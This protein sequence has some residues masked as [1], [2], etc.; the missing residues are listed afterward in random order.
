MDTMN[1]LPVLAASAIHRTYRLPR[2]GPGHRRHRDALRGVDVAVGGG[3]TLGI[4]GES[5]SGKSTLARILAGLDAPTAGTVNFAGRAV[6]AR[7]PRRLRWLRREVQMIFQDPATSLDPRMTVER[8]IGEPL[9]C[10]GIEG[11]HGGRIDE[12]LDEVELGGWAKSRLPHQLSGGQQ[13][14]VAIA[15]AIAAGPSVLIGDEPVSA[16]DVGVRLQ[17][18][19][20]LRR[21]VEERR[22]ALVLISH[23]LGVVRYLCRDVSVL[24]EGVVV[25]HGPT[26]RVFSAPS[27]VYTRRLVAAVPRL[28]I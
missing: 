1:N 14:R 17:I 12:V 11:D 18:L 2:T 26:D 7:H 9:E 20:L 19:D 21:L 25:E 3:E 10:L 4:V 8:S 6:D 27:D 13:Q 24:R 16:L 15:R 28:P 22:M 23:D 5:G